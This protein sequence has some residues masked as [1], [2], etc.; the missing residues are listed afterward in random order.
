MT[1]RPSSSST[2]RAS[3]PASSDRRHRD[4]RGIG[5]RGGH[6]QADRAVGRP[7]TERPAGS[8]AGRP[9]RIDYGIDTRAM[10]VKMAVLYAVALMRARMYQVPDLLQVHENERIALLF[11]GPVALVWKTHAP[12]I[13]L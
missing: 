4:R 2:S 10:L 8:R 12:L 11:D 13:C 9:L 6:R 7:D 1:A 3:T 5:I